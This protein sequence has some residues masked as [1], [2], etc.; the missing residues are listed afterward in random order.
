M[1]MDEIDAVAYTR[2]QLP[3]KMMQ[4]ALLSHLS[5]SAGPGMYGCLSVGVHAARAIAASAGKPLVGVHHMVSSRF[6]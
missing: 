5:W 4:G 1:V 3:A 2:G 6:P